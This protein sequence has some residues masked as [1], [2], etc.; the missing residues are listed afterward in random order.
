MNSKHARRTIRTLAIA[1]TLV[2]CLFASEAHAT[3][4]Y[5][6]DFATDHDGWTYMDFNAGQECKWEIVSGALQEKSN[7]AQGLFQSSYTSDSTDYTVSVKARSIGDGNDSM[8]II[9]NYVDARNYWFFAWSDP[10]NYYSS[11]VQRIQQYIDGTSYI[12]ASNTPTGLVRNIWCTMSV[13]VSGGT[14]T[15]KVDGTT[16]LTYSASPSLNYNGVFT[17]DSDGGI[18]YDDYAIDEVGTSGD[19]PSKDSDGNYYISEYWQYV[20]STSTTYTT[21]ETLQFTPASTD[22]QWVVVA[23]WRTKDTTAEDAISRKV[24]RARI[25]VNGVTRTGLDAIGGEHFSS[26][27]QAFG[28]FFKI[29]GTASQ[30]TITLQWA[31]DD[32]TDRWDRARI[33]AFKIPNPNEADIQ[34]F[35]DLGPDTNLVQTDYSLTFTPSSEGDYIIMASATGHEGPGG[36][37]TYPLMQFIDHASIVQSRT[38]DSWFSSTAPYVSLFHVQK[39]N[40]T[41]ASKTF[42]IQH[43]VDLTSGSDIRHVCMLAFRA[44]VFA[45]AQYASSTTDSS[46]TLT[47]WQTYLTLSPTGTTTPRDN[48]YLAAFHRNPDG[49]GYH[50]ICRITFDYS[51]YIYDSIT[52]RGGAD[53]M[54]AMGYADTSTGDKRIS[55][56]YKA[57]TAES[58][59][60][61]GGYILAL[62]YPTGNTAE[63]PYCEGAATPSTN[64]TDTT[65]EFSAIYNDVGTLSTATYYEIEVDTKSTFDG[66][67]MWDTGKTSMTALA[68]N[69]RSTDVSYAGTALALNGITYY[70]RI[71]FWDNSG[72]MGLW[73]ATQQF[74]MQCTTGTY[75]WEWGENSNCEF[76]GVWGDLYLDEGWSGTYNMGAAILIRVG[77]DGT[78]TVRKVRIM[79]ETDFSNINIS[80]SN[81][82]A[83][84]RL[85]Y[86][87]ISDLYTQIVRCYKVKKDWTPGNNGYSTADDEEDE[88]CW[89]YQYYDETTWTTAGCD[90]T[91]DR[92]TTQD[93]SNSVTAINTWYYWDVTTSA[94]AIFDAGQYYGWILISD[95]EGIAARSMIRF[96][97]DNNATV[98][99][100]P[101]LQIQYTASNPP[102]PPQTPYCEGAATPVTGVTDTTPEFSAIYDDANTTDTAAYYEIEVDTLSTFAGTRMW[103]TDKTAMASLAENVRSIDVSYAGTALTSGTYYWRIRFWDNTGEQGEWSATQQFSFTTNTAPSI[104][105]IALLFDN[106]KVIATPAFKFTGTDPQSDNVD[107]QIRWDTDINFGT[108]TTKSSSDYPT[109]AGWTAATFSSGS[110]VTY[111]VQS[112]LTNGTTYWW[113][114]QT[115]DPAG[116]NTWS[117]WTTARSF[118][119]DTSVTAPTWHQTT[120]E[121][122]DNDTATGTVAPQAATDDVRMDGP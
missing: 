71:R 111:T 109:D 76:Q 55:L 20:D 70:W 116:T 75:T 91:A 110:Q 56:E 77:D 51:T 105:T 86:K 83:Y 2:L 16:V 18:Q 107:Y 35:E 24:G 3:Q 67:R 119:I 72:G 80:S 112:A 22:E 88:T 74:T 45:N 73:S 53:T 5:S 36:A 17:A 113:Q 81:Q 98:A 97:S 78:D 79:A 100:R 32:N 31:A 52:H 63:S 96:S 39:A 50:D 93:A 47:S 21:L 8:G 15:C 68:D 7:S 121:Q 82:I 60:A 92:N 90:N 9:F 10:E 29:T 49:T 12:R 30:Q 104:P 25:Q 95:E 44:D 13:Q 62:S 26:N 94:K 41:A 69:T 61:Q 89:T 114:V 6:D 101:Y 42:K 59:D 66:K 103:D 19:G 120:K 65:P 87:T 34:Y 106:E 40:L 102:L 1:A 118:T 64:V 28:T 122:F 85:Y 46:T 43:N 38:D 37:R 54:M 58:A 33:M 27:F 11:T 117:G 57:A 4:V 99:N 23:T 14:I 48:V 84:A 108:A 115:R